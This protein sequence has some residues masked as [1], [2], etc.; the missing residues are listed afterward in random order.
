MLLHRLCKRGATS[1]NGLKA[2]IRDG[3]GGPGQ[4]VGQVYGESVIDQ[5]CI[6]HKLK[7]IRD[8]CRT[9]LQGDDHQEERRQLMQEAKAVYHAENAEQAK[10]WL[11]VW[12]R[13][14]SE[15]APK[16]VATFE[17]DFDAT[18]AYYQ[19]EGVALQ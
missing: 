16:S 4:A 14:W 7:N 15:V 6:F 5:R 19:L 1:E 13:R 18:I 9:E 12:S 17:R 3:C 11:A 8:A 2:I 10:E